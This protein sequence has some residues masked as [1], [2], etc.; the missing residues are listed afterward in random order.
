MADIILNT[1]KALTL[2]GGSTVFMST[3]ILLKALTFT[4][5]NIH[6][7]GKTLFNNTDT[8]NFSELERIER[9]MDLLETIKIYESW[10][11][12]IIDKKKNVIEK[13]N[14]FKLALTSVHNVL[15]ELHTLLKNIDNKV[16]YNKSVWFSNFR[17]Y[18]YTNDLYELKVKKNILDKRFNILQQIKFDI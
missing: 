16:Q 17:G 14:T 3:D 10:I 1:S 18:D 12:E 4:A 9:E 7:V 13:S 5:S 2:V 11:I 6:F 15:E 8:T